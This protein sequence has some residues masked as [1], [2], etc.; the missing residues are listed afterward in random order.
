MPEVAFLNGRFLPLA[1]ATVSIEDRGFQFGDGVYE[2]I[3]TYRGR[4]F[5]VAAH[6]ARLDRSARAIQLHQPYPEARWSQ[7]IL[8]GIERAAYPESKIYLQVTRGAAP[9]D[10]SYAA[11]LVP[12][13]VMTVREL[14]PIAA[15]VKSRGVAAMTT[16]DIRW[17]R[18]DVKSINLLAN[19]LARQQAK[20]TG[21]YETILVK[22]GS[23][24][25]GSVSNVV[26]VRD[27]SLITAPEGPRI[28]SGV[29]RAVVLRLARDHGVAVHERYP[30][31]GDLFA[32]EEVFLTGTTVEVLGVVEID[33]KTV[34]SGQP[35]RLTNR[36]AEW[37][38]AQTV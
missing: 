24:T 26:V 27:G 25:E 12:T 16:E 5:E 1:D 8:E 10:H 23:V 35:G 20:Q 34:G 14:Q 36:I 15:A 17:G 7:L 33:G 3:R 37:F 31:Q 28:L 19:V 6:L 30:S 11:D 2:V 18:C 13:V 4:P 38:S 32:A 21:V 22:D 29:T 9:R